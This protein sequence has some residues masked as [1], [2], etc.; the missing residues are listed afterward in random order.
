MFSTK[1]NFGNKTKLKNIIKENNINII[2]H[3]AAS[4]SI[5][6]VSKKKKYYYKNNYLNTKSNRCL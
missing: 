2:I 6:K 4:T 1:V 3:L 5:E